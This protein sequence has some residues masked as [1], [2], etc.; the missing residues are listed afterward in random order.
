MSAP[1]A[2]PPDKQAIARKAA[3][4]VAWNYLSFGLGKALVF[5]TTA[6]LARLLTPDDVGIVAIATLAVNYLSIAKDLGLGAALIQRR[7]DVDEAANTVFT[8]NLLLGVVLTLVTMLVAPL[9]AAY[10]R[11]PLVTPVLR[12]LGLSFA[13]EAVG[14]VHTVRLQ[15]QLEFRR[16]LV[17][18]LGRALVKGIVSIGLALGGSGVWALVYGQLAGVVASVVLAW[19]IFRWRPR[20]TVN[21]TLAKALLSFGLTVIGVDALAIIIDNF[22][23]LIIGRAFGD[24]ALGIYT[25]AYRLPELLVINILWVM[26]SV[27]F[28]TYASMQDQ[29]D[30]MRQ[31]FL[32]TV[33]FVQI[34]TVPICLGLIITAGP[35]VRVAFGEQWL[36][37]I[38]I[39]RVLAFYAWVISVGYHVGG[40]YKAIG[41]PDISVKLSILT[42]IVLVPALLIGSRYGLIG[43]A[44]GH[45]V[46][47][48][49]RTTV[50]LIVATRFIDIK[51][52][53][54]F[55]QLKPAALGGV[56]LAALALPA[57]YL[58]P[59]LP[60]LPRLLAVTAAGAGG[61]AGVLWLTERESLLRVGRM[62]GLPGTGKGPV[63]A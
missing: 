57:L 63:P 31:G 29:P 38:P 49:V 30:A 4:A 13:L 53:D 60:A 36:E 27:I 41:R 46:A 5:V 37:A 15:R 23:Y 10:F 20:L 48:L 44:F 6:I 28:P 54:I 21:T 1:E 24:A 59:T 52:G 3:H 33:R 61:Y 14:A 43:V 34:L 58:T 40:I 62:I 12:W 55:A 7:D 11:Q 8:L 35:L 50:R 17:P 47:S 16:K 32:A 39:V 56:A 2:S 9:A 22:D 19:A 18:D 45:V 26:G 25:F 42:L 51:P